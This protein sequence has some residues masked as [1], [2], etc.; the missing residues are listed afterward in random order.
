MNG[1]ITDKIELSGRSIQFRVL[2]IKVPVDSLHFN[3]RFKEECMR[4][5]NTLNRGTWSLSK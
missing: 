3:R 2:F 1:C 4:F 5:L